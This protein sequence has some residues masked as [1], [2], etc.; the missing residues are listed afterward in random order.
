MAW[1]IPNSAR[2][3]KRRWEVWSGRY[4]GGRSFQGAQVFNI[5]NIPFNTARRSLDFMPRGSFGGVDFNIMGSI[6]VHCPFVSSILIVLQ[7]Q[8]FMYSLF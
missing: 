1:N 6:R 8:D 5:H 4:L 7:N 2:S 3:C